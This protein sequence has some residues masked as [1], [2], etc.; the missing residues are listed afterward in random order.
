MAA[1][2][3]P[4]PI[5]MVMAV[6]AVVNGGSLLKPYIV[7]EVRDST[8]HVIHKGEK[9][10]RYQV[11]SKPT[12]DFV[13]NAM[14]MVVSDGGGKA[15]KSDKVKIGGKTGTAQIASGGEYSKGHYVASFVGFWPADKPKYV[16]LV[17]LGEPKGARYY[18]GQISA[19]IFKSI[20]ED[21][22]QIVPEKVK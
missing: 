4:Q 16:M 6:S 7:K 20:A 5:Q 3:L 11:I 22:E 14:K 21:V 1:T 18:G 19:P 9:R 15:A 2:H 13:R 8:G 17:S 10:V 12:A